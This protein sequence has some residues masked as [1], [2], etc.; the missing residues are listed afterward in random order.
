MARRAE[1]EDEWRFRP[2]RLAE[3]SHFTPEEAVDRVS[4]ARYLY[5]AAARTSHCEVFSYECSSGWAIVPDL[6]VACRTLIRDNGG[7]LRISSR[8]AA[9]RG[10]TAW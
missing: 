8:W 10:S 9:G 7:Q 1:R 6:R 5:D 2:Y 3:K 4:T